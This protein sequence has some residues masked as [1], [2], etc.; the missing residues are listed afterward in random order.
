MR[1]NFF[2]SS[3]VLANLAVSLLAAVSL[4]SIIATAR[5]PQAAPAQTFR[6]AQPSA[7]AGGCE[8]C[9]SIQPFTQHDRNDLQEWFAKELPKKVPGACVDPQKADHALVVGVSGEELTRPSLAP[10]IPTFLQSVL[11]LGFFRRETAQS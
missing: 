4:L 5:P 9:Y 2:F 1:R 11:S 7:S 6:F 3:A 8:I 10:C